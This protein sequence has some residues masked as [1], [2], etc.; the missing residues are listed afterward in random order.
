[1]EQY[2]KTG[3]EL[4]AQERKE[5]IEKHRY[6]IEWDV[7]RNTENQLLSAIMMLA[8]AISFRRG[9]IE[10]PPDALQDLHPIGWDINYCKKMISRSDIDILGK[11][12]AFA[13]AEIDVI[14]LQNQT[15]SL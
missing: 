13:A 12:G 1:M 15:A 11:I 7:V 5:Q 6:T 10:M 2:I 8:S 4:I 9:E 3:I 14:L